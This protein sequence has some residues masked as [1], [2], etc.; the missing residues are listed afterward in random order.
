[1][2]I[3][4]LHAGFGD[5]QFGYAG[6]EKESAEAPDLLLR[7]FLDDSKV[8]DTALYGDKF[9]FL[10]YKGSGKTAIAERAR[11]LALENPKLFAT[12]HQL[13][14]FSYSDFKTAAGGGGDHQTR[15]PMTWGW[16]VL[17]A[18]V[19]SL[20]KDEEGCA[21]SGS[22]YTNVVK[23]LAELGLMPLPEL[24][25]LVTHSS[26]KSFKATLPHFLEARVERVQSA[27]DLRMRQMV[28]LLIE[29]VGNFETDSRHV[30]FIDGLDSLVTQRELQLQSQAA[31]VHEVNNLN[32]R[33]A[34][35]GKPFK[36]VVL[37][38]TDM[39]DL[40]PGANTNKIRQDSAMELDWYDNPRTPEHTR[41]VRLVNLRARTTL[42][43]NVN[44][45]KEFFPPQL[46][47]RPARL[48]ILD[49]TR[50]VPRDMLQLMRRLQQHAEGDGPLT[51]ERAMAGIRSYSNE[52]FIPELKNELAGHLNDGEIS[53]AIRL[54]NTLSAPQFTLGQ[55]RD[56]MQQLKLKLD[57][58]AM[59]EALFECS[60]IGMVSYSNHD[61]PLYTFKYRNRNASWLPDEKMIIHPGARKGLNIETARRSRARRR[62]RADTAD[63]PARLSGDS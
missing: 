27:Q 15:Y 58:E 29:A 28:D 10:G 21:R 35:K 7:A 47:N 36:V 50:H 23:G 56:Q 13:L 60:G 25:Q 2:A 12:V 42:Q 22:G 18:L 41:L 34:S 20:Q 19:D 38:R 16:L 1:M 62:A 44:V 33:F 51:Q 17:L 48:S 24:G 11:L 8:V 53:T 52:Y 57:L 59:L 46:A 45:F 39:F 26:K 9:L 54:L 4:T 61:K 31:L 6:A 37:C 3:A 40:F 32:N 5:I 30:I 49:H 55:L 43:R 63:R 14:D